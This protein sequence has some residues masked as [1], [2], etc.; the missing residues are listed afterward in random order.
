M[1]LLG[2]LLAAP[3]RILEIPVKV[4][5]KNIIDTGVSD[6]LEDVA[7]DIEDIDD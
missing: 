5:D 3:V 7:D 1:G 6:V 4:V 2:D